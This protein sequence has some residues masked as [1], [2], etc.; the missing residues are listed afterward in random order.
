MSS[1]SIFRRL[2]A[3]AAVLCALIVVF[4][5]TTP[6]RARPTFRGQC[7]DPYPRQR[8]PSNPLM[9]SPAPTGSDPLQGAQFFV[10]GP[11]HGS[12]AG[13]IA[14][15]LGIDTGTPLGS[16]LPSFSDSDSWATF[17]DRVARRLP[18]LRPGVAYQVRMLEKIASQPEAQRISLYSEGGSPAGIFSQTQKLFCHNFTADP[19]TIPIISTYFMHAKLHGCPTT[20]D[21]NAYR[22]L[23]QRQIDAM[24]RGTGRRPAVYLLE[25]DAIGS[26]GCIRQNGSLAAWES[27]LRYEA[28]TMASLPHTVVYI[29][30]GYH[31]ATTPSFA[32]RVLNAGGI[33]H[34]EGFFTNDTHIN[35]AI[36]EIHYGEQI[37]R[38]T[39]GAHFI[40]NTAQDGNGPKLNRHPSTQGSEDL[41]N[42]PGRGLGPQD[43]T[44]TGYPNLDG[45]L[46]THV[47]GNSSGCGGGPPAGDFWPL[48]AI[49]LASRANDRLG[50][51]YPSRPY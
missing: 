26:T 49:G 28:V 37:S 22:P 39:H 9:L 8:D 43:T 11:K 30:G 41:C 17:S 46:W 38:M 6:T 31:D 32:A 20:G 10:D 33:D 40:V 47:P 44:T 36:D 12:A 35:W 3:F 50:P 18:N 48:R 7:S 13:A 1:P 24:A 21:I 25:L 15:L 5:A 45:L 4:S 23:F 16:A 19:G 2:P 51:G 34:V 42:P 14:H 27:M 29:E